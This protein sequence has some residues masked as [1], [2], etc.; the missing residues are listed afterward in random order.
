[1]ER[2]FKKAEKLSSFKT[3]EDRDESMKES[4]LLQM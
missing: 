2:N 1:M 3:F 4:E